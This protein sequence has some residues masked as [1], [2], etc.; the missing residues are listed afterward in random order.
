M[1]RLLGQQACGI[2]YFSPHKA[3]VTDLTPGFLSGYWGSELR[4]LT[5]MQQTLYLLSPLPP[6]LS[7]TNIV[8]S[9]S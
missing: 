5:F 1:A 7:I 6:S 9:V 2:A 4:F 8:C 3:E